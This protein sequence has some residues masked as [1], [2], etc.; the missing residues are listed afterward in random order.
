MLEE[1]LAESVHAWYELEENLLEV[2]MEVGFLI[3]DSLI[4]EIADIVA[5]FFN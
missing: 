3:E 2:K 4:C 1:D 5:H